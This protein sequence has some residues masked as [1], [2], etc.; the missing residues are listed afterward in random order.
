MGPIFGKVRSFCHFWAESSGQSR[1]LDSPASY[2]ACAAYE[3]G[4]IA[5]IGMTL[6]DIEI[7]FEV[8]QGFR[9]KRIEVQDLLVYI[10]NHPGVLE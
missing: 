6:A 7:A 9:A 1:V 5:G 10:E 3:L 4:K 8:S 2:A